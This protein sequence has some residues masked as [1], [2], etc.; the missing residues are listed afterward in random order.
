M[1]TASPSDPNAAISLDMAKLQ[2]AAFEA[3]NDMIRAS[4]HD[5]LDVVAQLIPTFLQEIS[6]TFT[7]SV[8][9]G[10]AREKQA[11]LQGQ[12]CGV[13]TV[14]CWLASALLRVGRPVTVGLPFSD[15]V[16]MMMYHTAALHDAAPMQMHA[17]PCFVQ[18]QPNPEYMH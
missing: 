1:K 10:E 5:T 6:R 17:E 13:L 9:S 11:E 2:I 12:L 18:P 16:Y 3:I 8:A 4:S 7:M 14:R 15:S